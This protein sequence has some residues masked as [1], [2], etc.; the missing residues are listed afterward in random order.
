MTG[1]LGRALYLPAC[2][3]FL[4][5]SKNEQRFRPLE[6]DRVYLPLCKVTDTPFHIQ[7]AFFSHDKSR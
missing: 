6:Y 2:V 4:Y 5:C 3:V 7:G 1:E